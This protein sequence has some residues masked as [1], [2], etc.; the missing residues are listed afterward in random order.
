MGPANKVRVYVS[1]ADSAG[2]PLPNY[3]NLKLEI[4]ESGQLVAAETISE[5]WS[6]F[7]VLV[8]DLSGSMAGDK[9]HQA[10]AAMQRY[11]ALAPVPYQIAIVGFSDSPRLI[12]EFTNDKSV[13]ESRLE[14]LSTGGNTALQDAIAYAMDLFKSEGRRYVL[15][16]TDGIENKSRLEAGASGKLDLIRAARSKAVTISVVGVGTDVDSRY[17][18]EFETTGGSYLEAARPDQVSHLFEQAIGSV[19]TEEVLEYT[20]RQSA[21]GL[22]EK[23]EARLVSARAGTN[24]ESV[25]DQVQV[26]RHGFIPQVKGLLAPYFGG[27]IILLALPAIWSVGESI[28]SVRR[29][30]SAHLSYLRSTS[31]EVGASDPNG[32]VLLVGHPIVS[33]PTCSRAHSVRSWRNNRCA[34][35]VEPHGRGSVCLHHGYPVWL[36]RSLDFLTGHRLTTMGRTWLCR[37]AGDNGGY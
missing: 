26:V 3:G 10:K 17:L 36:R 22:R 25:A 11:I 2:N 9:L 31:P 4:Y 30:R 12:S 35:M 24:S 21:D 29:F 7:S 23:L 15:A 1:L 27:L 37:C 32:V 20:T 33:C 19:A 34:C 28:G 13:L 8:L 6:V 18:R 14:H 5:G 16:L